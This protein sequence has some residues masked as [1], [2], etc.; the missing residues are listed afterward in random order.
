MAITVEDLAYLPFISKGR[1]ARRKPARAY[2]IAEVVLKEEFRVRGTEGKY[3][4]YV[5]GRGDTGGM[6]HLFGELEPT[7]IMS[8]RADDSGS[9][10]EAIEWRL[11]IFE[12][13]KPIRKL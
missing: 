5:A 6:L 4:F 12:S 13:Y 7:L 2:E 1:E 9:M 8:E 10:A 11:S 3:Q